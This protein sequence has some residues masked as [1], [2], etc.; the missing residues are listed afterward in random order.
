MVIASEGIRFPDLRQMVC[1]WINEMS[2]LRASLDSYDAVT[3]MGKDARTFVMKCLLCNGKGTKVMDRMEGERLSPCPDCEGRGEIRLIGDPTS[4]KLIL[5][6][7]GLIDK[8]GKGFAQQININAGNSQKISVE[9]IVA[10]ADAIMQDRLR[11]LT[12]AT[13][14]VNATEEDSR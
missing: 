7:A 12:P 1:D 6:T 11:L 10:K 13:I 9:D 4:R 3:D 2:K 8:A 5:A 14:T